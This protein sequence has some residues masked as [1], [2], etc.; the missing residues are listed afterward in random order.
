MQV[1][2]INAIWCS[3]CLIMNKT[4]KKVLEAKN[5]DK[6]NLDYDMDEEEVQKYNPGDKLPI[7]IFMKNNKEVKRLVGEHSYEELISII[8]ELENE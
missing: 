8:E 6:I 1:I 3:G 2:K 5:I 4:W 7:L